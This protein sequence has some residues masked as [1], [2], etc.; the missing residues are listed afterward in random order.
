MKRYND[1]KISSIPLVGEIPF[2]WNEIKLKNL[3]TNRSDNF[4]DGPFG[5]DLKT[6]HYTDSGIPIIQLNNLKDGE[7]INKN[8]KYT[9]ED[10]ANK[11]KRSNIFPGDIVI[12]KMMPVARAAIVNNEYDR[13]LIS[14][15]CIKFLVDEEKIDKRFLVYA[16]NCNYFRSNAESH[17]TGSTRLRTNLSLVKNFK[18]LYPPLQ[19][20]VAIANFL[21]EKSV[22]I[23]T[24]IKHKKILLETLQKYRQSLISENVTRGLNPHAKMK[25]SGVEWIG[26]IPEHWEVKKIKYLLDDIRIG[27][28]GSSLKLDEM[29][30]SYQY[31]VY[32]QENLISN[33]FTLGHR[34]ISNEKYKKMIQYKVSQGDLL[35]SMMGTIGKSQVVPSTY[36]SGI[37]DSHLM[38][39]KIKT[40]MAIPK[41]ISFV[42][43]KS[44]YVEEF[45]RINS[46]GSIMSGLN[47]KI[48]KSISIAL[49]PLEEQKNIL[50]FIK[51]KSEEIEIAVNKIF[52]QIEVLQKYRQS[53][54]YEAVTGKIDVRNYNESDLE[55]KR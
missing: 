42:I 38:K 53:L 13:Y 9:S 3:T 32:G 21:N 49:P 50:E 45:L 11:L 29:N 14:S 54:I 51:N 34:F 28:F 12:T 36:T 52:N 15:D 1:Y 39:L 31:K 25:D 18:V 7:H 10:K 55:V 6:E 20:Q 5:S 46:K 33:N 23:Q 40:N 2:H 35:I 22:H 41:Y 43:D 27:P 37:I 16:I 30:E 8:T 4:V 19:E 47:S 17:S 48:V 26:P 24:I 44:N